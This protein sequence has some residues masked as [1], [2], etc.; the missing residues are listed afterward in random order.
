[1][2]LAVDISNT[3]TVLGLYKDKQ[4][5]AD[6]RITTDRLKTSDE[7]GLLLLNLFA[8]R[9]IAPRLVKAIIISSVVPP[10]IGAWERMCSQ[11]FGLEPML[12]GPGIKTGLSIKMENP[13]EVGADRIVNAVAALEK[14]GGPLIVIDFSTATSFDIISKQ[15]EYIGG[16]IAPGLWI[17]VEALVQRTAQLPRIELVRPKRVIGKNTVSSMQAG[18][19]YGAVGQVNEIVRRLK[20][21]LGSDAYVVATGD[22]A[23]VISQETDEIDEVNPLLTLEGLRILYER[24][25]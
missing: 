1:M 12:V 15:G 10:V 6:W 11:Y 21:E 18:V 19:M 9:Q 8:H 24:N 17:S 2:V 3:H 23:G 5:V 20:K 14:Y 25:Q 4:L 13:K 7:Y 22:F 16:V